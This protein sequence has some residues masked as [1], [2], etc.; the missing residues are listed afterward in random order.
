MQSEREVQNQ[1]KSVVS[2]LEKEFQSIRKSLKFWKEGNK[3]LFG[4]SPTE[5]LQNSIELFVKEH[6]QFNS[7]AFIDSSGQSVIGVS[8]DNNNETLEDI[9]RYQ[10]D[11][12]RIENYRFDHSKQSIIIES[13]HQYSRIIL[14]QTEN[15]SENKKKKS[16]KSIRKG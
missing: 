8:V 3:N 6:E 7:M 13:P 16:K 2:E 12:P 1:V 11:P 4:N 9:I 15:K 10:K 14:A 5:E